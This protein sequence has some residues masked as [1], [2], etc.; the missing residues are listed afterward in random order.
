M[1]AT[2][3][4]Y[5]ST[6]KKRPRN[7]LQKQP[8]KESLQMWM[9]SIPLSACSS[10]ITVYNAPQKN[11]KTSDTEFAITLLLTLRNY[12]INGS[13]IFVISDL[14][15]TAVLSDIFLLFLLHTEPPPFDTYTTFLHP[16][17]VP[18]WQDSYA[19]ERHYQSDEST[20]HH[21]L[22]SF[23]DEITSSRSYSYISTDRKN[24]TL[25]SCQ[26]IILWRNDS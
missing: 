19:L 1:S 8:F 23:K 3:F 12:F 26:Q 9:D 6:Y 11:A 25:H 7:C 13:E 16:K 22:L 17:V 18:S 4:I 2:I 24:S 10:H 15:E 21:W 5:L 20:Y 14:L